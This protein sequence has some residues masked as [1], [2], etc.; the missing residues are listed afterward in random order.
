MITLRVVFPP[1]QGILPNGVV[2]AIKT[3]SGE[4]ISKRPVFEIEVQITSKLQHANIH[5]LLGCCIEGD[6]R[7]LVYEYI[8]RGSLHFMIHGI[9]T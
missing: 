2:I 6:N 7:I 4:H 5:K 3:C 1:F 9:L 8:P